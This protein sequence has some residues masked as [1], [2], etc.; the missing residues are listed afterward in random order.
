VSLS[1]IELR[2]CE[3][4]L[5][6]ARRRATVADFRA[7]LQRERIYSR[8]W[9]PIFEALGLICVPVSPGSEERFLTFKASN[10][11]PFA[12]RATSAPPAECMQGGG[13]A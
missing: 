8:T 3:I 5:A 12:P 2:T 4:L 6:A 13:A 11:V 1:K 10:V 7:D 9:L